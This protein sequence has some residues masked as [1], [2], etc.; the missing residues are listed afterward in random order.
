MP[1]G[2]ITTGKKVRADE[3]ILDPFSYS[4]T[5][6]LM[7]GWANMAIMFSAPMRAAMVVAD[8][9]VRPLNGERD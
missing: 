5:S 1:C 7:Q 3:S 9:V 2:P 6:A 4:Q 8:E